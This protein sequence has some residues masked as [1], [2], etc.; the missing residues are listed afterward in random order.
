MSGD[1]SPAA[2][3]GSASPSPGASA[4][5]PAADEPT[6]VFVGG[7]ATA[8]A[9]L[10]GPNVQAFPALVGDRL[11]WNVANAGRAEAGYLEGDAA[12]GLAQTV[13][14][15][16]R[17]Q[18]D[19][20]VVADGR[21]DLGAA[22]ARLTSGVAD[23]FTALRAAVGPDVPIVALS[24]LWDAGQP[25]PGLA[26]VADAVQSGVEAVMGPT[27]TSGSRCGGS[28]ARAA[29]RGAA[30]RPGAPGGRAGRRAAAGPGAAARVAGRP[31][32]TRAKSTMQATMPRASTAKAATCCS[33]A[34]WR[35]RRPGPPAREGVVPLD[36][37]Q[38][39]HGWPSS[40]ESCG[41]PPPRVPLVWTG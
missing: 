3:S 39:G 1:P 38:V 12:P 24:P 22:P 18:P 41:V 33:S 27:S 4:G 16:A 31:G 29:R 23:Y 40:V 34:R 14:R 6:V 7:S 36:D 2:A 19:A 26:A 28:R 9:G 30:E 17:A 20:V 13:G 32:H 37:A 35:G 8:G 21:G 11:G 15:I 25:A 5:G 10:P